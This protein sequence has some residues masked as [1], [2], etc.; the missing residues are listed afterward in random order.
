MTN[1]KKNDYK[2]CEVGLF[3]LLA[4]FFLCFDLKMCG[5]MFETLELRE[6]EVDKKKSLLVSL[7]QLIASSVPTIVDLEVILKCVSD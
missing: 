2:P 1:A 4:F 3:V 7:Y 6:K 5:L